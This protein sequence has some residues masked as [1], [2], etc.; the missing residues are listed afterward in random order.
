[1]KEDLKEIMDGCVG[2]IQR[3]RNP[4]LPAVAMPMATR[5]NE[6]VAI[7][8][9]VWD[10]DKYILYMVDI[11]S[12]MTQAAVISRKQPKQ[13][14]NGICLKW[15]AHYGVMGTLMHD[16]GGE[17]TG[18]E[19]KDMCSLFNVVDAS[20][21][22]YSPWQNGICEKHH[23]TVDD[24]LERLVADYPEYRLD[25]LLAWALMVKNSAY[26]QHGFSPNQLV[27]GAN[28]ALPSVLTEGVSA[29]TRRRH[30]R[31]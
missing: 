7:D 12:K 20:T 27:Y 26:D 30:Q 31:L 18:Q 15:V 16:C 23:A 13:V 4:D 19:V 10:K 8:L 11:W 24:T 3:R 29:Q 17:F 21:A 2:C 14:V 5:F 9:K 22:G 28:P 6:K 25:V 1:M